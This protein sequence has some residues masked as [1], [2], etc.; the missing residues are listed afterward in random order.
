[1]SDNFNCKMR[2][3]DSQIKHSASQE[4][5]SIRSWYYSLPMAEREQL[6]RDTSDLIAVSERLA[7]Q[8]LF[9]KLTCDWSQYDENGKLCSDIGA[10]QSPE[11]FLEAIN[12]WDE[13]ERFALA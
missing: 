10:R 4:L 8:N 7:D 1:M 6:R 9:V 2:K 13:A 11:R 5:A 3:Y 12:Q